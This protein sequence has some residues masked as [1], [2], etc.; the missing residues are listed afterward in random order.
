MILEEVKNGRGQKTTKW[1]WTPQNTSPFFYTTVCCE[2]FVAHAQV[3]L[4]TVLE[5]MG[6]IYKH[7]YFGRLYGTFACNRKEMD[8]RIHNAPHSYFIIS[9]YNANAYIA[10][11][12]PQRS[13]Y[14][15]QMSMVV[16]WNLFLCKLWN[17]W[18]H[19]KTGDWN[20]WFQS[21]CHEHVILWYI[22][23]NI[24]CIWPLSDLVTN[25]LLSVLLRYNF[26]C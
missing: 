15:L 1:F 9:A 10:K 21:P 6:L 24:L 14:L 19:T 26:I 4:Q 22:L 2:N 13:L 25:R 16:F 11:Y 17:S 20:A 23:L 3:H 5:N 12:S 7:I 18:S 8:L